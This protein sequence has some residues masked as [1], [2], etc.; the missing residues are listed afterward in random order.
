MTD[1][2]VIDYTSRDFSSLRT[3]MLAYAAVAAPEWKGAQGGGDSNDLGVVLIEALAYQGD[4]LS[5]YQDRMANE[6]FLATATQRSSVLSHA[7]LL[8]YVPRSATA[9]TV[10]VVFTVTAPDGVTLPEGFQVSTTPDEGYEPLVFELQADLVVPASALPQ[11]MPTTVTEGTTIE[12]EIVGT[13]CADLD[14][15]FTLSQTPVIAD[16][17]VIRVVERPADPGQVWFPVN[18]LLDAAASDNAYSYELGGD[19]SYTIHFGDNVS[20]RVPP[21]GAVIHARYRI[22]GG[23]DGNVGAGTI[24]EIVNPADIVLPA[25]STNLPV[26][27][28]TNPTAAAGGT[29]SESLESIRRNVPRALRANQRGVSLADYEALALTVPAIQIA[30]AKA[31]GQVYTNITIFIAPP[32][33]AMPSQAMLNAVVD[34]FATRKMAGATVVAATPQ[35]VAIDLGME[36]IVDERYSQTMVQQRVQAAM[37]NLLAFEKVSFG[38]RFSLA[39]VYTTAQ[40]VEG[41]RNVII[42]TLA[43]TGGSGTTDIV[44]HDNELPAVG[45]LTLKATGGV[46]NSGAATSTGGGVTPSASTAPVL[47]LLRCDPNSSHIEVHWAAGANTTSWD[48]VVA[49]LNAANI[50]I[51]STIAGPY[52][53]ANANIDLPLTGDSRI[54]QISFTTRAYNGNVGPVLS[55]ATTTAY[56]CG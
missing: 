32:G 5:Y 9:A 16:S 43:R 4:I 25:G 34:Y 27:A 42:S 21:R 52:S 31:V 24:I 37:N 40:A 33:G 14:A 20:G 11:T 7:R 44:L 15:T 28:V 1:L 35:Y 30:K 41:V 38:G 47:D 10:G 6:S 19:D 23:T 48:I 51:T 29:D 55:P 26:I 50:V 13:S 17:V 54:T 8:G 36:I 18:N 2:P 56:A 3:S 49:Y 39:D 22:G 46:V 53:V 12:D 45:T